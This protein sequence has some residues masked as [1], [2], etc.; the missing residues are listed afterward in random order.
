MSDSQNRKLC[1][2]DEGGERRMIYPPENLKKMVIE[3]AEDNIESV[4]MTLNNIIDKV[5]CNTCKIE[6]RKITLKEKVYRLDEYFRRENSVICYNKKFS[7]SKT[8]CRILKKHFTE[9]PPRKKS[10]LKE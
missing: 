2:Y 5:Y 6:A 7:F 4:S 3:T 10:N 1:T 8:V 9:N